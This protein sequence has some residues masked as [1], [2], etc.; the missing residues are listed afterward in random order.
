M[1]PITPAPELVDAAHALETRAVYRH[2]S[3]W[4]V[5]KVR[6]DDRVSWLNGQ[7]TNDVRQI[8]SET[9]VHALSVNVRGKI[10]AEIWALDA[11][12]VISES[13]LLL[14]PARTQ[15][16]LLENLERYV[17]MEDVILEPGPE[18]GILG[19]EG[20]AA[21][22]LAQQIQAPE[23]VRRRCDPLGLGG[24][25]WIGTEAALAGIVTQLEQLGIT[26]IASAAYE[27]VRLRRGLPRYTQD[28]DE[29]NYPQEAGLKSLVSFQKGCY[30]G[31]EVVCTLENRGRL[32]RRLCVLQGTDDR[33]P[34]PATPLT[35]AGSDGQP[36]E[37]I[38]AVTSAAW[39]QEHRVAH[40]L[41]YLK[42]THIALGATVH[43]GSVP[44]T[45]VSVV[46]DGDGD[47]KGEA[48]ASATK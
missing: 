36:L 2:W 38:G 27:L 16:T 11:S 18:L 43:A 28:F 8:G 25:V 23:V 15:T 21:E 39:D 14:V 45:I 42:R 3:E 1:Q 31:Q 44:L 22:S 35:A 24:C 37:P 32:S 34:A 26:G 41:G 5:V 19:L 13:L 9:S 40:V 48:A 10:L 17:I 7:I 46:G 29:H 6:G 20:P 12:P 4:S 30:L 47:V 33:L